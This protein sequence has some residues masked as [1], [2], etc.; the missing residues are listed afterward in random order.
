MGK[1][2]IHWGGTRDAGQQKRARS[3]HDKGTPYCRRGVG[4]LDERGDRRQT[5]HGILDLGHVTRREHHKQ[6]G[7]ERERGGL[8]CLDVGQVKRQ[9]TRDT[10]HGARRQ[11]FPDGVTPTRAR[12]WMVEIVAGWSKECEGLRHTGRRG[13]YCM[14]VCMEKARHDG[15]QQGAV[16][17]GTITEDKGMIS[18]ECGKE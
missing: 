14:Y 12:R 16:G 8:Y 5:G 13:M 1:T 9:R 3:R 11:T 18:I 2:I 7:H 4:Q 10:G 17:Q 6:A 15:R